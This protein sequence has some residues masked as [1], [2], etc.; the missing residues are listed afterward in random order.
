M[1]GKKKILIISAY[2]EMTVIAKRVKLDN[3]KVVNPKNI[4]ELE[5]AI[6]EFKGK[7][8]GTLVVEDV[9]KV[10]T[11]SSLAIKKNNTLAKENVLKDTSHPFEKYI[12]K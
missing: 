7:G 4:E 11:D 2:E 6:E 1:E 8:K 3:V 10:I 9:A 12:K 5:K